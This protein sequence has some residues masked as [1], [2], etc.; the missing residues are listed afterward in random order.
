MGE[1]AFFTGGTELPTNGTCLKIAKLVW[2]E[3]RDAGVL[4]QAKHSNAVADIAWNGDYQYWVKKADAAA[5]NAYLLKWRMRD[6]L[7]DGVEWDG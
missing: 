7:P 3:I 1:H 5:I 6:S 4:V 2:P